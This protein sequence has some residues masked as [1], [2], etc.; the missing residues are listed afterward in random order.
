[1]IVAGWASNSKYAFL[2]ALRA[3]ARN[4]GSYE[5]AIGFVL[6]TVLL[7]SG[8]LNMSE[9]VHVQN[10]GWFADK[11]LTFLSWNWLPLCRCS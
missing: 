9:I 5:L 4:A 2:G 6:V 1:M 11:G 10:R 7:V 8:S 3:A